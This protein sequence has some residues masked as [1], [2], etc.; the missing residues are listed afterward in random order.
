[1]STPQASFVNN[2]NTVYLVDGSGYIFR[3]YYAVRP[4]HSPAGLP[5]NAVYGFCSM[6]LRLIKSYKPRHIAVT[7]DTP[8]PTFRHELYPEYKANRAAPPEDLIPQLPW[9]HRLVDTLGVCRL[10]QEG[11]EADDLIGTAARVAR[12]HDHPVCIVSSDKDMMQLVD[13]TTWLLRDVQGNQQGPDNVID[14]SGVRHKLGVRPDQVN[15][16]LALAGDASDNVPGV[17]GIGMKIAAAL[18]QQYGGLEETLRHASRIPQKARRQRLLENAEKARLSLRLTRIDRH[19]HGDKLQLQH[20]AYKGPNASRLQALMHELGF[21]SLLRNAFVQQLLENREGRGDA[22]NAA[23]AALECAGSTAS[24]DAAACVEG[25][26][27]PVKGKAVS[28]DPTPKRSAHLL[29]NQENATSITTVE[30]LSKA[31]PLWGR[32]ERIALHIETDPPEGFDAPVTGIALSWNRNQAAYIP[33]AHRHLSAAGDKQLPQATV[34]RALASVL[35]DAKRSLVAA[36]AKQHLHVLQRVGIGAVPRGD[37][38]LAG[39]LLQAHDDDVPTLAQLCEQHLRHPL[40][41]RQEVCGRGKKA[42]SFAEIPLDKAAA[43]A[44]AQARAAWQLSPLLE[45]T[46]EHHQ[47]RGLYDELELPLQRVLQR[48]ETCGVLLN[49]AHLRQL[50]QQFGADLL[51]LQHQAWELAGRPFNLASAKQVADV[52]FGKLGLQPVKATKTGQSTD[53]AVLQQLAP[54]HPLAAILLQHRHL[55]KLKGTY[56]D[57]LPALINPRTGRLHTCFNALVTAT[58]RLSSSDPNLQNIPVRS[59]QGRE[60]RRSFI[61]DAGNVLISLDYS[62]IELRI[63]AHMSQDPVLLHSFAHDED[64]HQRTAGEIFGV[65]MEQVSA[66]QRGI[67]K[68]IN[69]GL[70]YGM[71]P[72]RLSKELD[73]STKEAKATI[74]RYNERYAGVAAWQRQ[75]VE[76]AKQTGEVRTLLGRRRV[77]PTI[78]SRNHMLAARAERTAINTPVQGTAADLI[79]Q[80]MLRADAVLADRFPRARLLLQVHD[81]LLVE[82]PASDA[83]AAME[84]VRD[85]MTNAAALTVPLVV[86]TG[87]GS[88]WADIH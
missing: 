47:L 87:V 18:I 15:D 11:Y 32:A 69:F 28:S 19:A 64:V 24:S 76:Q 77:L 38:L 67:A 8:T 83:Q 58:G 79:K 30:D 23:P 12:E 37:P 65:S 73:I 63:L 61:A 81:E 13:E 50:G 66:Q 52:L 85:A 40:S 34:W 29:Q 10:V 55:A 44:C 2:P 59:A 14:P 48:M 75:L 49:T 3:A 60:I 31:K 70:L 68:T 72:F 51:A 20:W 78:T 33:L 36:N 56:I 1:M 22:M 86:N 27:V 4:L 84:A 5:T 9:I 45:Q 6:L 41:P 16:L 43:H 80:A 57:A 62:Q 74:E 25:K 53:A 39:Y 82:C 54:Q 35:N 26:A 88:C 21:R 46:L 17:P 71:G 7:F 42:L